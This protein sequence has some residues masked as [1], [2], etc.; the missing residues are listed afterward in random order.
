MR[1][2][3]TQ[4]FTRVRIGVSPSTASGVIRKPQGEKVVHN[5]ILSKFKPHEMEELRRVFKRA[6]GALCVIITQGREH[7]MNEF[8]TSK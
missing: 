7:A 3:K 6:E 5:F 2:V 1:A 4:K 8:N